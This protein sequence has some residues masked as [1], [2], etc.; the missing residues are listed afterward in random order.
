M[1]TSN[2]PRWP[3]D[4]TTPFILHL[5]QDL[6][7]LG[8]DVQVLAPHAPGARVAESMGGVPVTRFRYLWPESLQTVC[9]QGGALVNLRRDRRNFLKLPF[10]VASEWA[11]VMSRLLRF[12]PDLVHSHWLLPQGLTSGLAARTLRIPHVATVHGGDVFAL[13]GTVMRGCKKLALMLSDAVTVN[14][15][16]TSQAVTQ[17]ASLHE[18]LIRIPM[19]ASGLDCPDE[20]THRDLR[21]RHRRGDGPLLAFV[22]RLVEEKGVADLLHAVA[23]LAPTLPHV[24]AVIVG[25]GP[26][27]LALKR[28]ATDLGIVDRI[29]FA[30][31]IPAAEVPCYL[32]AADVFVGPSKHAADG[33]IEAQGL[34]FIEAMLAGTPVIATACGGIIDAVRHE[35]TGLLIRENMPNDIADAV[36][37]LA[38]DPVL[39]KRLRENAR[40]LAG[41]E[42]TREASARAFSSLFDSVLAK[43][44]GRLGADGLRD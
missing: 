38:Q 28:L 37:R 14:S 7:Q 16:A 2:F 25:D 43:R 17:L 33:W 27:L 40:A 21:A 35:S 23:M 34:T 22:G 24:T 12:R 42:F 19:G 26:E 32:R 39:R 1:V 5:A 3:G 11:A 30:G 4:S 6:S 18:K 10:L 44:D 20:A 13:N 31:W 36:R 15:S 41:R 8:W 29:G 9:Y